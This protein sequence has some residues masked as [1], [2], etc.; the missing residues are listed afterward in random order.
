[1]KLPTG[2][3]QPTIVYP[4]NPSFFDVINTESTLETL[5]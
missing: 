2:T 3:D 1:M 5:R 4:F